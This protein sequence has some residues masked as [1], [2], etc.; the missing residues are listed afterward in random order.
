LRKHLNTLFVT[1]Q[2]T[3]LR[4]EG[5]TLVAQNDGVVKMRVPLHM[6]E[7]VVCFG[8]VMVTPF[9]MGRCAERKIGIAFMTERGRFLARVQPAVSGNVLLRRSQ[10]RWADDKKCT[11]QIARACVTGKIWL[12]PGL[13]TM[14]PGVSD[15]EMGF[16]MTSA[17]S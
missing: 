15:R 1:T 14:E 17:G 2:R 11:G 5:E 7:G 13:A 9:L 8:N 16:S 6:L 4:A 3:Y 12:Y 10:Y